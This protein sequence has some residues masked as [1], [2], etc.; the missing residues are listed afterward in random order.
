MPFNVKNPIHC[1]TEPTFDCMKPYIL[2]A[3]LFVVMIYGP[4]LSPKL[5]DV[6]K[7]LFN[8]LLFRALIMFLVLYSCT[9]NVGVLMSIAIVILFMILM[10]LLQTGHLMENFQQE[11]F[12]GHA[13]YENFEGSMYGPP[14]SA[15]KS[16]DMDQA[17][18]VGTPHYPMMD[19][20]N[21]S[22]GANYQ[23][24]NYMAAQTNVNNA[25]GMTGPFKESF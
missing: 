11:N 14:V 23:Q 16:Y 5:P 8:N 22:P 25:V 3:L 1:A 10:N 20:T 15:C 17:N 21:I 2:G 24:L 7:T 13:Q 6:V 4:R 9:N 19:R 12:R 18:F